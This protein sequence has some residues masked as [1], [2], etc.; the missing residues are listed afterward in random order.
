MDTLSRYL[1]SMGQSRKKYFK[2]GQRGREE[3]GE[4][5]K[6]GTKYFSTL[7]D[8]RTIQISRKNIE[9]CQAPLEIK[10]RIY[11]DMSNDLLL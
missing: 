10:F 2:I 9:K 6:V 8:T 3:H 5:E 11:N 7:W 4:R 1:F